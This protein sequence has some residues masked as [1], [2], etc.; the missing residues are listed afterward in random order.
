M[1]KDEKF[2]KHSSKEMG[3]LIVKEAIVVEDKSGEGNAQDKTLS[4][5]EAIEDV[6][7]SLSQDYAGL[8]NME[9]IKLIGLMQDHLTEMRYS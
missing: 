9:V 2:K 8:K 7:V 1:K 6:K 4:L 5:T 3:A